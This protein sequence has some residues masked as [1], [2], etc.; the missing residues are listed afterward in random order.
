MLWMEL[1]TVI[2]CF[3]SAAINAGGRAR[4]VKLMNLLAY[5][6]SAQGTSTGACSL[7]QSSSSVGVHERFRLDAH[8]R[9]EIVAGVP[10]LVVT[11]QKLHPS[12]RIRGKGGVLLEPI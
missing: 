11:Q 9:V 10:R 4:S 1:G 7:R 3:A 12:R 6:I 5:W 2:C 8:H